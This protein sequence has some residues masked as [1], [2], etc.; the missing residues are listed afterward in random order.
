MGMGV[1]RAVA[2]DGDRVVEFNRRLAEESEDVVLDPAVLR[3]GVEAALRDPA[4]SLYFVAE[5]GDR[6]VGQTMVT[7]EWSDW[8]NGWIWWIQSVYV[9]PAAR[10]RGVFKALHRRVEEEARAAGAVGLRLYVLDRNTRARAVYARLGMEDAGY[11][12]LETM[13]GPT[14]HAGAPDPEVK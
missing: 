9:E 12:V 6:V 5:D 14:A 8:R 2:G 7:F 4:R 11:R 13:F 3:P 10:E 1:R